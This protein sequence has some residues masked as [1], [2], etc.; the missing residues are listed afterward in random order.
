MSD[1][2]TTTE[3]HDEVLSSHSYDGIQEYDNPTPGWWNWFFVATIVFA[4]FYILWFHSPVVE[5]N[6]QAQYQT[7]M[8]ENLKLQFG[9]LVLEPT[10]ENVLT[11]LNDEQWIAFGK[12]TF[13]THCVQCHGREGEGV[14]APNMTDDYYINVKTIGDIPKVVTEGAKNGA[15]PAWGSKLHP[16]EIVFVSSYVA[17][18]RGQNLTST[19]NAEGNEIPPWPEAPPAAEPEADAA[20]TDE[21]PAPAE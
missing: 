2:P 9:D 12:T 4:P 6:L 17:S 8:A 3:E 21:Q 15:M 14:S 16:N 1:T 20:P 5:R 11:Y 13:A 10:A 7:A 19:R 18:I